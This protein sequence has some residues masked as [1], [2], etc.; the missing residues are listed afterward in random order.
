MSLPYATHPRI[1]TTPTHTRAASPPP[2]GCL[3]GPRGLLFDGQGHFLIADQNV[4]LNIP[5]AIYEYE[6]TTGAFIKALVSYTAIHAPPAPRGIILYPRKGGGTTLFVASP[7]GVTTDPTVQGSL[8][9]FDATGTFMPLTPPTTLMSSFHPRGVVIGPDG[10]LYVSNDPGT[11]VGNGGQIL[12]YDPETLNFIDIFVDNNVC[13]CDFN[14]PEGLVFGP[15]GNLYVT[16]F[17][18]NA[19]DTDKILIFA[20]PKN[21]SP[22]TLILPGGIELDQVGQDRA[23]AQAL[24]FG[25]GPVSDH[26]YLFVP[27]TTPTGSNSGEVRRYDV[28]NFNSISYDILVP[29]SSKQNSPLGSSWYLTFGYTDPVTLEYSPP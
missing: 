10:A 15:D 24:L 1:C 14:R 23:Y 16:S 20:G 28:T 21:L 18:A 22:G 3:Y 8:Q 6:S 19:S 2:A 11:S 12:R 4:N 7:A 27:I 5:G 17:R 13:N 29:A 25:P 26:V 9:A